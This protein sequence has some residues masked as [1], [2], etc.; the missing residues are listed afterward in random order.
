MRSAAPVRA[1]LSR[2]T[3]AACVIRPG[4]SVSFSHLWALM[5]FTM[6]DFLAFAGGMG[7]ALSANVSPGAGS[8]ACLQ[9]HASRRASFLPP[10]SIFHGKRGSGWL[11][12]QTEWPHTVARHRPERLHSHDCAAFQMH[13]QAAAF[14]Y[15]GIR[16]ARHPGGMAGVDAVERCR[17]PAVRCS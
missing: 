3:C 6:V 8:Q 10:P 11:I 17:C 14:L 1:I 16:W 15:Y 7:R 4:A 12:L 2:S 9:R 13:S 5:F